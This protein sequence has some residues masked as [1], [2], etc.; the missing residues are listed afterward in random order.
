MNTL[1]LLVIKNS[2]HCAKKRIFARYTQ[3]YDDQWFLF[4]AKT[5]L[6]VNDELHSTHSI[7][8]GF[9]VKIPIVSDK[10]VIK[11]VLMSIKTTIYELEELDKSK[12]YSFGLIYDTVW[13]KYSDKFNLTENG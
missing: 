2:L 4:D 3:P 13:G 10:M 7:K 9:N 5:K 1:I 8:N 11:V 12:D 6:F